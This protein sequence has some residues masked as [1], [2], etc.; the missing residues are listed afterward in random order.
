[1]CRALT[2]VLGEALVAEFTE[3]LEAL[4]QIPHLLL[5]V[6]VFLVQHVLFGVALQR[7]NH[8]LVHFCG[9]STDRN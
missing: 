7:R 6:H 4:V 1:M 5:Q 9:G 8:V 2:A 3:A